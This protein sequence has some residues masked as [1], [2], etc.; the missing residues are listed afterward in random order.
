M[1]H[2]IDQTGRAVVLRAWPPRRIVSLVPSQTE[3]LHELGLHEQVV[4]ITKFCVHPRA[5]QQSKPRVGGTKTLNFEKIA[6]RL[7]QDRVV[8]YDFA[9][10][11]VV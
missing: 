4:G 6:A 1:F 7:L 3:W 11:A 8:K 9:R 10:N 5:W 2:V